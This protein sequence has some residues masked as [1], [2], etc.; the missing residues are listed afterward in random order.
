MRQW[1]Y[2]VLLLFIGICSVY[3]DDEH[4][5]YATPMPSNTN[6]DTLQLIE[7]Q[8]IEPQDSLPVDMFRPDPIKAVWLGTILPGAGQIYNRSYWK[9]PIVYGAFMG[10]AYGISWFNGKYTD[11][12][13]A[14]RDIVTD[15]NYSETD[16]TKTYVAILPNGY[17]I[18]TMGGKASYT[19]TLQ[20]AQ[21]NYRRYRDLMIVATIAV[22]ALSLIDAYVDA[23]LFDFDISTDLSMGISPDFMQ[24]AMGGQLAGVCVAIRF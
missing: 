18:S 19:T 8:T 1:F 14:Y 15:P 5:V 23:Q 2:I 6:A 3:A 9:L 22:Y 10:C 17:S 20:N 11:Y 4:W 21:N 24:P 16:P 13:N 12:K 7:A